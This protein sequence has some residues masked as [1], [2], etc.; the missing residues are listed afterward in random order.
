MNAAGLI[1][2]NIHDTTIPE[3]TRTRTMASLPFGC[4]Y[5]LVD[6]ALSNLVN[7]GI[8]KVGIITHNN[9][10]SLLEH[11]GSGRDWD[12]EREV[13]GIKILPP[14]ITS[15]ENAS[16]DR[17]Y[18][19]RLEALIAVMSFISECSEEH[20]VLSDCDVICNIDLAEVIEKH[21]ERG[22]DI[23][24][25]TKRISP[26]KLHLT[27]RVTVVRADGD[28]RICDFAEYTSEDG[29]K[30]EIEVSM[31][32]MIAKKYY[33]LKLIED[34]VAHGYTS[35]EHQLIGQRLGEDRFFA[36]GHGGYYA[37]VNRLESYYRCSL[38]LLDPE[39]RRR[40]FGI[41][42]RPVMT[43]MLNL[44]P[45]KYMTGARVANSLVAD[46]C[47]IEGMVENSIVFRGV[48]VGR[49][50]T[51]RNCVL[52]DDTYVGEGAELYCV[53]TDRDVLIKDGRRLSGHE[54]LPF[55]IGKGVSV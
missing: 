2:S 50:A 38:E 9:Y 29:R 34:A 20:M 27:P 28:G 37:L 43:R 17:V 54:T 19:S 33:L 55:F 5:R 31:N 51:V 39:V 15:Y 1:F 35:F 36:F 14:F 49:G 42:D 7:A 40:L 18:S 32:I 41:P 52:L 21:A 8:T 10:K 48:R 22:A 26:K 16:S 4:R 25:V 44:P 24:I 23:T 53:V 11:L 6:F 13:G 46:G 45:T 30:N 3:L 12:L 47:V